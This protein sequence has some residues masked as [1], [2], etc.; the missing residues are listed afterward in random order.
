[1][2]AT[3]QKRP[4][5]RT[6]VVRGDRV[7]DDRLQPWQGRLGQDGAYLR[8]RLGGKRRATTATMVMGAHRQQLE[9][10]RSET[11]AS[12]G[13]RRP[14]A[15]RPACRSR[16]P[17][18]GRARI[19]TT[20]LSRP[21]RAPA[22]ARS[23]R[24]GSASKSVRS[25]K[26]SGRAS[27]RRPPTTAWP[28]A[29]TESFAARAVRAVAPG[30]APSIARS[31]RPGGITPGTHIR[32]RTPASVKTYSQ[33]TWGTPVIRRGQRG[34]SSPRSWTHSASAPAMS[35]DGGG[36]ISMT[37]ARAA[38]RAC[39]QRSTAVRASTTVPNVPRAAAITTGAC[40]TKN[41]HTRRTASMGS[42]RNRSAGD[43]WTL[44]PGR[45]RVRRVRP[46]PSCRSRARWARPGCGTR[47]AGIRS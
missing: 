11:G 47:R 15:Y 38:S 42:S 31:I 43:G 9:E 24:S 22:A 12:P 6:G 44:M 28:N 45:R 4:P 32:M 25:G 5:T 23:P 41:S 8:G 10:T 40:G 35:T 19:W 14:V 46:G 30:Q 37:R 3:A 27:L 18:T 34:R 1:M 2:G 29:K 39:L 7:P 36:R 17:V 13:E 20:T 26:W 21:V 33:A 16:R